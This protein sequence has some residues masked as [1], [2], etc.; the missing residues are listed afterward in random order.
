MTT[1]QSPGYGADVD[2]MTLTLKG[3]RALRRGAF[4]VAPCLALSLEHIS[5]RGTGA[6]ITARSEQATWLGVGAG[7][8]GRVYL[9]NWF[10]LLVGVDAQV[11]TAHPRISIDGVGNLGQLGLAAFTLTLGPEWIL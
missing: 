3:C 4:E 9:A 7:A 6:G 11:E 8:Q 2:R 10:S 1:E 5:A